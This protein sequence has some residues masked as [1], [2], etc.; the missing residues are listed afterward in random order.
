MQL[1]KQIRQKLSFTNN[2][3]YI[4]LGL[5]MDVIYNIINLALDV[6][7]KIDTFHN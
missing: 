2:I 1:L 5:D 4:N 3:I 7:H 6:D